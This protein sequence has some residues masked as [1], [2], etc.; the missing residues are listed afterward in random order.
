MEVLPVHHKLLTKWL[1]CFVTLIV[2]AYCFP[3]RF[4]VYGGLLSLAVAATVLWLVNLAIRPILQLLALPITL[5][6]F[7]LFSLIVNAGMVRLTDFILP[8]IRIHGFFTYLLIALAISIANSV[9]AV[10]RHKS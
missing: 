5:L 3:F 1:I 9:L 6:T 7:G 10:N 4:T 2:A 8:V